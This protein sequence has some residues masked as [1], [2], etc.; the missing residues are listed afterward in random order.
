MQKIPGDTSNISLCLEK[1][2][3]YCERIRVDF[4]V[5]KNWKETVLIDG[6]RINMFNEDKNFRSYRVSKTNS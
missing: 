6:R 5:Y 1:G 3:T 2:V 4:D